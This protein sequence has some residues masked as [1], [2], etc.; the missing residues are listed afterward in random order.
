MSM[1]DVQVEFVAVKKPRGTVIKQRKDG[2][3]LV[4]IEMTQEELNQVVDES[5][6]I[7]DN[8]KNSRQ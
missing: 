1:G 5:L 7:I 6:E 3:T 8:K 4:R 2:S